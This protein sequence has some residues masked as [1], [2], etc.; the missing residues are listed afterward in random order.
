MLGFVINRGQLKPPNKVF[1]F[2][3][4]ETQTLGKSRKARLKSLKTRLCE[5]KTRHLVWKNDVRGKYMMKMKVQFS[6]SKVFLNSNL[7]QTNL[8]LRVPIASR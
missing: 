7:I 2:P 4:S 5:V 3:R 8:S 1:V 6:H